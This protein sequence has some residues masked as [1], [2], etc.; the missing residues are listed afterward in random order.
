MTEDITKVPPSGEGMADNRIETMTVD[1][2]NEI[3]D[4]IFNGGGT[5]V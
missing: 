1:E 3:W 5:C 4:Q 2:I